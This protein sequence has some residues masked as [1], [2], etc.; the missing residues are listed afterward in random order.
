[1]ASQVD[2]T[3][4]ADNIR[5]DKSRMRQQFVYIKQEI[6]KLQRNTSIPWQIALGTQSL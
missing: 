4:P 3:F 6:E 1:M 2:T 5:V